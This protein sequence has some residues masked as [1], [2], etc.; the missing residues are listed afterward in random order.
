MST[1]KID[2]ESIYKYAREGMD[3]LCKFGRSVVDEIKTDVA[4]V[5]ERD[6]AAKSSVEIIL[7]YSGVH[8]LLAYRVSHKLYV[9]KH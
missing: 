3:K 8:A 5:K 2:T 1:Y 4:A 7:L 6:P 9:S